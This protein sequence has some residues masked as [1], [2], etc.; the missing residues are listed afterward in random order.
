MKRNGLARGKASTLVLV[1]GVVIFV[2]G[3]IYSVVVTV[4][5]AHAMGITG[6]DVVLSF[7]YVQRSLALTDF[8]SVL[9]AFACVAS[10]FA[11]IIWGL[12]AK[13]R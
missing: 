10:S 9:P 13:S 6:F 5:H 4:G 7:E 2:I 12:T 1:A 3:V 11:L 8:A